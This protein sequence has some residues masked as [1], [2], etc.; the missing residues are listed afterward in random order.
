[1]FKLVFFRKRGG[2]GVRSGDVQKKNMNVEYG[3][4]ATENLHR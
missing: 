3:F 4:S 2:L 1:M